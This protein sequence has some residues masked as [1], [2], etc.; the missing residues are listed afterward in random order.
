MLNMIKSDIF[1]ILKGKAIYIIFIIIMIILCLD[2]I[3]MSAGNLG[4]SSDFTEGIQD[5]INA[6]D[7]KTEEHFQMSIHSFKEIREYAKK[8]PFPIDKDIISNNTNL[9]YFFI[10]ITVIVLATD[11]SNKSI[12]NTLSSAITRKKYYAAK[13]L[14]IFALSTI[15]ILFNNY[16]GYFLNL[17]V[18]GHDFASGFGEFTKLTIIQLPLLYGIISLLICFVFVFKKTSSFYTISIPF[19]F[20]VQLIGMTIIN[21]FKINGDIFL[22]YEVQFAL[23]NLISNPAN[24]YIAKCVILGIVYIIAFNILGYYL[25]RKTEIE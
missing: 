17:I 12:K 15:V 24:D 5:G 10:A 6:N 4:F 9:Y 23:T 19:I 18:N 20:V 8:H 7:A 3:V 21:L 11:F 14:T 22:K 2:V 25:F 13:L 1:R 16:F